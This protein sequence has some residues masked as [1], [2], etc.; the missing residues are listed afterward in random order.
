MMLLS[1]SGSSLR[2]ASDHSK[3]VATSLEKLSSGLRTNRAADD[4]AGLS[5]SERLRAQVIGA[6]QAGRNIQDAM[7]VVRIGLDGVQG[8][9]GPLHRIRELV[10]QAGNSTNGP[11]QLQA[12]QQEIDQQK[13]LVVEAYQL[14]Q[15]ANLDLGGPPGSRILTFQVGAN[16]DDTVTF[17]YTG[18]RDTMFKLTA[19]LFGY[20]ELYNSELAGTLALQLG[21]FAP[22]PNPF[23]QAL[24]PK[25]IDVTVPGGVNQAL[26][27]IDGAF[28]GAAA[29]P[30]LGL[31]AT[32]GLLIELAKLGAVHN[33][34]EHAYNV[35]KIGQENQAAAESRIRDVDMAGEMT[36]FT[37]GQLM[38]QSSLAMIAQANVRLGTMRSLIGA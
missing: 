23:T 5:I 12:I 8:L 3:R 15:K 33:R 24:V 22:P 6:S 7:S 26:L 19:H 17:N 38:Q 16:Q 14:A 37:R 4:A 11:S 1:L 32:D 30:T 10:V 18:L 21:G 9:L 13:Q 35:V 31:P 2:H 28:N 25:V 34:L 36:S 29:T 20:Q 27:A